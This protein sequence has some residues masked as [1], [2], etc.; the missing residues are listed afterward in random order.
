MV[1]GAVRVRNAMVALLGHALAPD[2]IDPVRNGEAWFAERIAPG[3]RTFVDVGANVGNWS[4]TMLQLAPDARGVLYEPSTLALARL[5]DR[6]GTDD[7]VAI[8][9]AAV[10]DAAGQLAFHE[11]PD[12]GE[13]SS[14][15]Q[16]HSAAGAQR[17][18]VRVVTLDASLTEL[19]VD[20]VDLLKIDAE[21]F[22]LH[23]LRGARQALA[24]GAVAAV[25]FEYNQPWARAGSTLGEAIDLLS[26]LGYEVSLL[27]RGGLYDVD[28]GRLG[29]LFVYAN[30]V[31]L[32]PGVRGRFAD[33]RRGSLLS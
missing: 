16:A 7:R 19:G 23:V 21:G 30:L 22:D 26:G 9:E 8:V 2:G 25:Q 29:E 17:R 14:L 24:A 13:T 10:S 32:G 12:A 3:L 15:L 20:A 18:E 4:S 27:R 6:L 33:A 11:E 1:G 5:R 28:Y 31:A